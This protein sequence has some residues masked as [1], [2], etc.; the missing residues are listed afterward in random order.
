[1]AS[2]RE[3][4][5]PESCL[6]ADQSVSTITSFH[7]DCH[8]FT[9]VIVMLELVVN[10]INEIIEPRNNLKLH[11]TQYRTFQGFGKRSFNLFATCELN[12]SVSR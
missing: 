4:A 3:S 5:G 12:L 2:I 6:V 8:L 11:L 9:R 10:L 1:M 7:G